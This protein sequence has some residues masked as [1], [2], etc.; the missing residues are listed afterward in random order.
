MKTKIYIFIF[1]GLCLW[2]C[3]KTETVPLCRLNKF[4]TEYPATNLIHHDL[5]SIK[6]NRIEKV[7]SYD[8][9]N[10]IDTIARQRIIYVIDALGKLSQIRDESNLTRII[11]FNFVYNAK[12]NVDK[13]IQ[14]T[15]NLQTNEIILEYDEKNR[16]TGAI[17]LNLIGLN[18][19]IEYDS[20]GNPFRITRADFGS[21][22]T[23]NEH[24]FDDKRNIFEGIPDI[25]LYWLLRPLYN[26]IPFGSNNIIGTKFYTIQSLDFKE[27]PDI[28]TSRETIYNVQGFPTEM[29]IVL[30]NQG[31]AIS[32]KSRFEYTCE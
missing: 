5:I 13:A 9:K 30:E 23:V 20:K 29:T 27:V 28:R 10:G 26:F 4:I 8:L 11:L 31:R 15:N 3:Q 12:G 16:P 6:N 22:A 17:S 25:G 18:R 19:S 32:S 14:L 7:Y 21:P 24:I 1:A 2:S